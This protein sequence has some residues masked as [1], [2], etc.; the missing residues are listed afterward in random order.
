M[1]RRVARV[2][3]LQVYIVMQ[4][5]WAS[6]AACSAIFS[7]LK[8]TIDSLLAMISLRESVGL[9]HRATLK[10]MPSS[11]NLLISMYTAL[12]SACFLAVASTR[13]LSAARCSRYLRW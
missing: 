8:L 5:A 11:S 3:A 9:N 6:S 4:S 13:A 1:I 2:A 12:D 10:A 7:A